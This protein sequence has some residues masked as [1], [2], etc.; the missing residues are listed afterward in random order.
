MLPD[1]PELELFKQ[2]YLY[3][4]VQYDRANDTMLIPT[5]RAF[6]EHNGNV[7]KTADT[8]FTHYNTV[9]YRLDRVCAI[10]G[11]DLDQSE[12]RLQMQIAMKLLND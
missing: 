2:R 10:V 9:I 11:V 8:L 4:L 7:R 6:F 3:P 5:L 1:G 12:D